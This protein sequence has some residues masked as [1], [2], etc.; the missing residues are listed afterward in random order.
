[1]AYIGAEGYLINT[2]L[3]PGK[4]HCQNHTPDFLRQTVTLCKSLTDAPLLFRMDSGNDAAENIGILLGEG[5]RFLVKRNLRKE[6]KEAWLEQIREGSGY[7]ASQRRKSRL[8]RLNMERNDHTGFPWL[9][10]DGHFAGCLRDYGTHDRQIRTD[11]SGSWC[12]SQYVPNE[13]PLSRP[14]PY[15]PLSRP[16]GIGAVPQR[17]EKRHES[18]TPPLREIQDQRAGF[19]IRDDSL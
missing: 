16:R 3:R 14:R 18:W 19:G 17:I 6:S 12:G 10:K 5:C 15:R 13:S 9:G 2:E 7:W 4:Q 8:Y 11:S 1:M